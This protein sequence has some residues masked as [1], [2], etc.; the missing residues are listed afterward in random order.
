MTTATATITPNPITYPHLDWDVL[1]PGE[2][3]FKDD[4]EMARGTH[5][6][7]KAQRWVD[8]HDHAH[9]YSDDSPLIF[10]GADR[11]TCTWSTS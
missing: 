10:C 9:I 11:E 7:Y 8:G 1:L 3:T 2:G 4:A 6:D 5:Y